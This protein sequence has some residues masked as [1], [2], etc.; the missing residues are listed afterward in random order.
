MNWPS[1]CLVSRHRIRE[2]AFGEPIEM[3]QAWRELPE[4]EFRPA[5][6]RVA[7]TETHLIVEATLRDDDVY[8][9]VGHF[10][11]QMYRHGDVFEMFVR[12]L[13]QDAYYEFHLSPANQRMQLRIPSSAQFSARRS[14]RDL[15]P[16]WFLRDLC[17]DSR[18]E[19]D[20]AEHIWRAWVAISR[21]RIEENGRADDW[22]VSFARYDYSRSRVAP[23]LSSASP[24]P[25]ADFHRQSEWLRVWLG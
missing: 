8:Q 10:N 9:P 6:V 19:V 23:V 5:W 2:I 1:S 22:L 11:A 21:A 25:V 13:N 14:A 18:V 20:P 3:K 16:E 17:F 15:P 7:P 24:H 12:P 4:P